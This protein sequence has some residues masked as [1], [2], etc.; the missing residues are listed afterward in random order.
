M[1]IEKR[2]NK[3]TENPQSML[4]LILSASSVSVSGKQLAFGKCH[5]S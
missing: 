5:C 1:Y 3:N 4:L 2:N